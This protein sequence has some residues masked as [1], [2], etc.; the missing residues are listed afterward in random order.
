M[1]ADWHKEGSVFPTEVVWR[2][3]LDFWAVLTGKC[4]S[5]WAVVRCICGS[6]VVPFL[7]WY[8]GPFLPIRSKITFKDFC[9]IEV[10]SHQKPHDSHRS[11]ANPDVL[12]GSTRSTTMTLSHLYVCVLWEQN[13]NFACKVGTF[14]RGLV[15]DLKVRLKVSLSQGYGQGLG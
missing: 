4:S 5:W 6:W 12:L 10:H 11:R 1:P 3:W 8:S 15:S 13:K 14:V 2:V 7:H 9:H